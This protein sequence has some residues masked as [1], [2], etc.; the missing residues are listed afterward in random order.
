MKHP[1]GGRD[2]D[3]SKFVEPD[4]FFSEDGLAVASGVDVD[5]FDGGRG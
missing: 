2:R 4:R 5:G 1:V 3:V